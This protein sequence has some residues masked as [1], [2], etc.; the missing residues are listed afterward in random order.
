MDAHGKNFSI[1]HNSGHVSLSPFYDLVST[2]FYQNLSQKMAMKI[3]KTY[4]IEEVT[5]LQWEKFSKEI[6]YRFSS[7]CKLIEKTADKINLF[8]DKNDDGIYTGPIIDYL[9]N[10]IDR[11]IK[12]LYQQTRW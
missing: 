8:L 7:L 1:L 11:Q 9:R 4:K 12:L 2:K 6:Q 10:H 3:S 5:S